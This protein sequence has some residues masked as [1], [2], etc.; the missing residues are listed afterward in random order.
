MKAAVF[1]GPHQPLEVQ[2]VPTP[3]PGPGELRV[4]VAACGVCHTDLHYVDHGTP[5]FRK[6]PLI[7]GHEASGRIDA[8]GPGVIGWKVGEPVLLP[9]VLTCGSCRACRLGRE[10]ICAEMRMFGNH[11]DGAY[12]EYV[13]APARDAFR[14]PPELPLEEA[15]I[16][17]D[18]VSTPYH[19]V[20]NRGQVRPGDSVAVFG[21]GGVGAN[22]VQLAVLAGATVYA[23]DPSVKRRALALALGA[24]A[25]LDP[26]Q[27][28]RVDKE[29]RSL[30]GEG[31]DV[32]FEAVGKAATLEA[33]LGS[34]R[35]GGRLCVIGF[36]VEN[37]GWP[38]AKV[39]FH[40][41]EIVGS[42]GCRPVDYPPLIALAAAGRLK[43]KPLVTG[44]FPLARIN[45]ALDECRQGRGVRSVVV[46]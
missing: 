37:P 1:H 34:L 28:A 42:L 35:R 43:L 5:T 23:V 11:V 19:A 20:K 27:G 6:P 38:A 21:V 14:L 30:T 40:E 15:C 44:R 45:D 26:G 29:L 13:V 24:T 22:V 33:A 9:A 36:S 18:A 8:L 39:M 25:A 31:V 2:E 17:A 46:P 41:I 12:A 16:I 10:N 7:L 4:R 32:A 3:A